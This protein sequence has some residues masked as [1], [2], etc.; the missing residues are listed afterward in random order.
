MK[1]ILITILL[2]VF[3]IP[4][5]PAQEMPDFSKIPA[6]QFLQYTIHRLKPDTQKEIWMK[7]SFLLMNL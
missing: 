7:M 5:L 6:E 4:V 2:S 1:K 3:L